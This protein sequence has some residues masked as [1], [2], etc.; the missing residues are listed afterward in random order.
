[1]TAGFSYL[2]KRELTQDEVNS[3]VVA[4]GKAG[5]KLRD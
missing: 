3:V 2:P 5:D 1:V 4:P